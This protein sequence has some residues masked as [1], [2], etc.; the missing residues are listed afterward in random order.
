MVIEF[1]TSNGI[2]I[3]FTV[4]LWAL[5]L[6]KSLKLHETWPP[7]VFRSEDFKIISFESNFL[8]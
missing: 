8:K 4:E 2:E 1:Y 5:F 7:C 6:Q 3:T